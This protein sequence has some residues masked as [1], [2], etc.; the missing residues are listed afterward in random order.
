[1]LSADTEVWDE[2]HPCS[3]KSWVMSNRQE[4]R[5]GIEELRCSHVPPFLVSSNEDGEIRSCS[6][7]FH[8]ACQRKHSS[9]CDPH[10]QKSGRWS[11][12]R[13]GTASRLFPDVSLIALGG[14]LMIHSSLESG[15]S[16]SKQRFAKIRGYKA[17]Q[18][19]ACSVI[20]TSIGWDTWVIWT[21]NTK[22]PQS[23][24]LFWNISG[25]NT[26]SVSLKS[27]WIKMNPVCL[28]DPCA[29]SYCKWFILSQKWTYPIVGSN[30]LI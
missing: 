1:M 16:R 27:T 23:D 6:L 29:R 15:A 3:S 7:G 24:S 19:H 2:S 17:F 26:V 18:V 4:R 11:V 21:I 28:F 20:Q 12:L 13:Q 25:W 22:I 8:V 10:C 14:S 5:E 30:N 9:G